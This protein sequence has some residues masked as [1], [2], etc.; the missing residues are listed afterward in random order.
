MD[1]QNGGGG[2]IMSHAIGSSKPWNKQFV[3]MI[4]LR[5]V[6]PGR[7]DKE[8]FQHVGFPIRLYPFVVLLLKRFLLLTARFLGRFMRDT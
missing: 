6:A 8:F 2:Y 1:F 5:A 4:L 7:A 3:R